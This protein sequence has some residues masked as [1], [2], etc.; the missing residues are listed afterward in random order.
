MESIKQ[1]EDSIIPTTDKCDNCGNTNADKYW[2]F[3]DKSVLCDKCYEQIG[4]EWENRKSKTN[5]SEKTNHHSSNKKLSKKIIAIAS[6][7]S[8]IMLIVVLI[9]IFGQTTSN[10]SKTNANNV[11][12]SET[13]T[14]STQNNFQT[15]TLEVLGGAY[16]LRPS[17]FRKD[18]PVKITA[19]YNDL[20][21]CSKS[22]TIPEFGVQK[23]IG[24]LDN[25]I[26]FT[27][28]KTGTFKIACSMDMY[29]GTFTVE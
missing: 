2:D 19:D 13:N 3:E 6:I 9:G 5:H 16:V 27:P 4:N 7:L 14:V 26:T 24:T 8:L 21:G 1:Q 29:R 22:V 10:E 18:I 12:I 17:V 11:K 20:P 15:A 28:T 25:I 23:R